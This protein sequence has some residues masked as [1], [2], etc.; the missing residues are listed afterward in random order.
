[1]INL[2]LAE[3]LNKKVSFHVLQTTSFIF[4]SIFIFQ[5]EASMN[6]ITHTAFCHLRTMLFLVFFFLHCLES[7]NVAFK[8]L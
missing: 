7:S 1:M 6:K 5:K 2:L 8:V 4:E 3:L